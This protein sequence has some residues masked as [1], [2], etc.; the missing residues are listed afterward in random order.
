MNAPFL[1]N[2]ETLSKHFRPAENAEM[3]GAEPMKQAP[4]SS[5]SS[6]AS[7][8]IYF[9]ADK[10]RESQSHLISSLYN[11]LR[12]RWIGSGS[13][14]SGPLSPHPRRTNQFRWW[15]EN[16]HPISRFDADC[17]EDSFP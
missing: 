4:P 10:A 11:E 16:L 3:K 14:T 13:A 1:I 2:A 8:L 9:S 12:I 15:P 17:I 5:P 6:S 7:S